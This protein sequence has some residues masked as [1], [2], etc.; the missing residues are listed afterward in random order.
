[1]ID[2]NQMLDK[3]FCRCYYIRLAMV[4]ADTVWL[5]NGL[6]FRLLVLACSLTVIAM[7]H[8][9]EG[10]FVCAQA[11]MS[12][13][14][15]GVRSSAG[16]LAQTMSHSQLPVSTQIRCCSHANSAASAVLQ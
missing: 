7:Q 4:P 8:V 16:I 1:M 13:S 9:G 15:Y 5:S 3:Q 14:Y 11:H 2:G 6:E 10:M 12:A